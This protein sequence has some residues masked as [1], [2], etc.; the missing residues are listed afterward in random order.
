MILKAVDFSDYPPAFFRPEVNKY[1]SY[2]NGYESTILIEEIDNFRVNISYNSP[3]IHFEHKLK[4]ES[5]HPLVVKFVHD[6]AIYIIEK[7]SE[8]VR[9]NIDGKFIYF[10]PVEKIRIKKS[11]YASSNSLI[12]INFPISENSSFNDYINNE[13]Q[14][15]KKKVRE[16]ID[17]HSWNEELLIEEKRFIYKWSSWTEIDYLSNQVISGRIIFIKS[18]AQNKPETYSF[19]YN[20]RDDKPI[21]FYSEFRQSFNMEDYIFKYI[22]SERN[23]QKKEKNELLFELPEINNYKHI[24]INEQELLISSD[25][26]FLFS[27]SI[28][29][30]PFSEVKGL[31]KRNSILKLIMQ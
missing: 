30:I 17:Q 18:W 8:K 27:Y 4:V 14:K 16:E 1:I 11:S 19:L 22:S 25:Y 2:H 6:H 28:Y 26:N 29:T 3:E 31:L 13:I 10:E 20:L 5:V 24:S 21:N 9:L 12:D 7:V 15:R 23:K